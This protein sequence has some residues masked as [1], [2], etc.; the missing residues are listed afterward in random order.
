MLSNTQFFN[1]TF[2]SA[3]TYPI[4]LVVT[5]GNGCVDSIIQNVTIYPVPTAQFSEST[6]CEG[7]PTMFANQSSIPAGS[8]STYYWNFGDGTT[9]IGVAPSHTYASAGNYITSLVVQSALGCIDTLIQS[10]N[11]NPNPIVSF[12]ANDVCHGDSTEFI[13]SSYVPNG[14]LSD[15]N[16][17]FGD[18]ASSTDLNP[19]HK[20]VQPGTYL[21]TLSVGSDQACNK[22]YSKD[23]T[24]NARP[25][26]AILAGNV[27]DGLPVSFVDNSTISSGTIS[28]YYWN[29]G[30]GTGSNNPNET[31]RRPSGSHRNARGQ[32]RP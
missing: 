32:T 31:H 10:L 14:I 8:I 18:G 6:V 9:G 16:W 2:P 23:V 28:G 7:N 12:S 5:S 26:A 13:N 20:Y 21:V 27:C 29:F 15:I 24:V 1:Y 19:K 4:K 22:I 17:D 30:D 11:V 25:S 3:G